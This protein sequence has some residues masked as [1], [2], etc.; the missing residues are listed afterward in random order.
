MQLETRTILRTTKTDDQYG[1]IG[2]PLYQTSNFRFREVGESTGYDYTRSGNPTRKA[3]ED[4]LAELEGGARA[5]AVSTGMAAIATVLSHFPVGA[6]VI[7]THDCYGGTA[8]LLKLFSDQGKLDV[9]FIDLSDLHS[10]RAAVK[11][12]TACLWIETPSNPLLQVVDVAALVKLAKVYGVLVAVDNTFLSP[13]FFQPLALGA[14]V[15]VHSTTKWLNGHSDVVGGAVI[16]RTPEL[17][18]RFQFLANALGTTTGS[19]DSWLVLRGV[20]TLHVRMRQHESNAQAVA[21]F[22][23]QHPRV[24]EVFYPGLPSHPTHEIA[25]AQQ[26]GFGGVVSFRVR[27][28]D[29]EDV[30]Q[31]LRSTHLFTLAESLGGVESLIE[32]PALMSHASMTPELRVAA[33]I[34]DNLIRLSIGIEHVDD[35]IADLDQALASVGS[36][37]LQDTVVEAIAC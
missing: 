18:A 2:T 26:S 5:V 25:K 35:L 27:S 37:I 36:H 8:R 31:V 13:F 9:S 33:G 17:G 1:S 14:D 3:L 24:A 15:V 11:P 29:I 30:K 6:H 19:F 16:S 21:E 34:T 22:L 20:K 12:T 10:V 4:V 32:Q 28:E 7:A 23:A